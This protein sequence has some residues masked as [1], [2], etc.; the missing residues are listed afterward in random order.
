MQEPPIIE[1]SGGVV[2]IKYRPGSCCSDRAMS[3]R[4]LQKGVERA[5]KALRQHAAGDEYVIIDD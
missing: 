4:V 1:I 3:V 2:L 5:Q